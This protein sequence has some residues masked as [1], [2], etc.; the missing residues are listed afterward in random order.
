MKDITHVTKELSSALSEVQYV[1][2]DLSDI[3]NEIGIIIGKYINKKEMG[4][5]LEDFITGLKHGI[6]ITDGTHG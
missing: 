4:F 2:G 5:E 6:S 1:Q 3:G